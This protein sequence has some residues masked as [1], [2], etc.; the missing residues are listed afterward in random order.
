M[1]VLAQEVVRAARDDE[2]FP[3]VG[4]RTDEAR[5]TVTLMAQAL[6]ELNMRWE[7]TPWQE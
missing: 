2:P 1:V 7:N 5:E 6:I 4:V 3:I